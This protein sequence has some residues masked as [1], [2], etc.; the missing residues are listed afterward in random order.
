MP[1]GMIL[2]AWD[3]QDVAGVVAL[4]PLNEKNICEMKRLFVRNDWRGQGLGERLASKIIKFSTSVGYSKMR[5]D[6]EARLKEA[7]KLYKKLGFIE[8]E[9]YYN[10]PLDN[11]IYMERNLS[12]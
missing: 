6:T 8:I 3:G 11:I 1:N 10:N 5:I 12:V 4:R 7:I 9:K 2:L